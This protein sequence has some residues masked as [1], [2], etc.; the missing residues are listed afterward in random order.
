MKREKK[1]APGW[2]RTK[3]GEISASPYSSEALQRLVTLLPLP[4]DADIKSLHREL[5]DWARFYLIAKQNF[6]LAP[7]PSD[8]RE[9]LTRVHNQAAGLRGTLSALDDESRGY[10]DRAGANDSTKNTPDPMEASS[11][12]LALG[13]IEGLIEKLDSLLKAAPKGGPRKVARPLF[14]H[15]LAKLWFEFIGKLP[16]RRHNA[17]APASEQEY[18]EFKDFVIAA[19]EALDPEDIKQ[20]LDDNIREAVNA[21]REAVKANRDMG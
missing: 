21:I 10:L 3:I 19:V 20:G 5:Q 7:R 4:D 17:Y 12:A 1:S 15:G 8:I 18:G 2:R 16:T 13:Q 14:V 9:T 11:T 6:D